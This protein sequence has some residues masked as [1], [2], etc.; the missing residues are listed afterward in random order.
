M[1]SLTRH[2]PHNSSVIEGSLF[3]EKKLTNEGKVR[4]LKNKK[5]SFPFQ[6][7][8]SF[9][10]VDTVITVPQQHTPIPST[11]EGHNTTS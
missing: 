10:L 7:E 6:M 8:K 9:S 11:R 4:K 3:R 2:R 5:N 1:E